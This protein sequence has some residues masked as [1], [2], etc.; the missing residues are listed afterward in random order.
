MTTGQPPSA[1]GVVANGWYDRAHGRVF[2]WNRSN[3]LIERPQIF[4][5][6]HARA[7]EAKTASL[8]WR[9]GAHS[10]ADLNVIERPTYWASGRKS[11]DFYTEPNDWHGRAHEALG[12]FPFPFFWGPLAGWKSTDWILRLTE[13]VLRE[14]RPTLTL[15][16]APFLDY[17]GQRYGPD[18]PRALAALQQLDAGLAPLLAAAEALGV[19][20]AVVS[21]YGFVSVSRPVYPNR[22]LREAGFIVV[23]DAAN[24]EVLETGRC[25]AFA[26]C[27]NQ[28]AQVYVAD[29]ADREPVA[30]LLAAV[31]GIDRVLGPAE[32]EAEGLAHARTGDLI[33]VAE[34]DAWFAY[35]YWLDASK[36]P[37]F[38]RCIAVFDK[39]GFDP[40]EL[41]APPGLGGKLHLGR[42]VLQ[43]KLGLAVPFDV[44]DPDGSRVRGARNVDRADTE[45][46]AVLITSWRRDGSAP[47]PTEAVHDI[48]LTRLFPGGAGDR[49]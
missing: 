22:H 27:D 32:I 2:N 39:P 29:P 43:K 37:D 30:A 38:A 1:H 23:H 25:R 6:V 34:R 16:Y 49:G 15:S 33:C 13:L 5:A 35:P 36:A 28:V 4:D 40:C 9:H 42:R 14:A 45:N 46:G 17:D 7:P 31:D 44:I 10:A 48:L 8:F 47:L 21:D 18:D 11:F 41:F 20:V 3:R 19:D 24:G 26:H 12:P